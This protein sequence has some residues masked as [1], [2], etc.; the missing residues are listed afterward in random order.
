MHLLGLELEERPLFLWESVGG[1]T[2]QSEV[3]NGPTPWNWPVLETKLESEE[4]RDF[5]P[6]RLS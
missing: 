2:A 5:L 3:S 4:F 6:L 1:V